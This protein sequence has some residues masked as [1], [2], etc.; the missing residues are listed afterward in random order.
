MLHVWLFRIGPK[1]RFG[2]H[3]FDFLAPR[4]TLKY[5]ILR[6]QSRLN[7][8]NTSYWREVEYIEYALFRNLWVN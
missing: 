2:K 4:K 3:D 1:V 6:S 8:M 5:I 7:V